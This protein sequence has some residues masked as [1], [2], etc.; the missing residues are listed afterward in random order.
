MEFYGSD[1]P[2][3]RFE[4][5]FTDMTEI[6]KGKILQFLTLQNILEAFVR[7]VVRNIPGNSLMNLLNLSGD[8][9]LEQKEWYMSGYNADGTLK[10]SVDKFYSPEELKKWAERMNAKPGDLILILAGERKKTLTALSELRL[11]M[12]N[13]LG[14][15]QKDKFVPLWV[16]DFPLLEWDEEEKRYLCDASSFYLT[17][18]GRSSFTGK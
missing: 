15:R 5:R 4:M 13:R 8:P 6:V 9:R 16:I 14:L 11:E 3:L 7:Q 1:K 10:S 17:Y 2:D 12:G 18:T